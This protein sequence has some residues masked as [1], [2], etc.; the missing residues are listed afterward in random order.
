MVKSSRASISDNNSNSIGDDGLLH[1]VYVGDQTVA[2]LKKIHL[3]IIA[4]TARL[5]ASGKPIYVLTDITKLGSINLQ[6]R[7]Y[8]VEIIKSVD[9][10]RV[11]IYGNPGAIEKII[12]FI[13]TASGRGF[14]MKYF[15]NEKEARKWLVVD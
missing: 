3:E 4:L 2:T 13:I 6:A 7:M 14:K 9:F 10:D 11:A 8:A 12:N 15:N 5:R 1:N